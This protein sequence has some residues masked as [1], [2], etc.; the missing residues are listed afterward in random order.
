MQFSRA[1]HNGRFVLICSILFLAGAFLRYQAGWLT[2]P[3]QTQ[4]PSPLVSSEPVVLPPGLREIVFN[5]YESID[6]GHYQEAYQHSLENKWVEREP[7]SYTSVGLTS[8]ENF[9][10]SLEEEF[11]I[12]GSDLNIVS[13]NLI[14]ATPLSREQWIPSQQPELNSIN[15]VSNEVED[16][17]EVQ[18]GGSLMERCSPWTWKTTVWAAKFNTGNWKILLLGIPNDQTSRMEYWF[19]G[20]NPFAHLHI[21]QEQ[22][23]R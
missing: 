17:Y 2:L 23:T 19:L 10:T 21:V 18:V 20:Q 6:R 15:N 11:G 12:N 13:M 22:T 9:V 14:S 16:I 1:Q 3:W 4:A 5:F 7:G 8:Q